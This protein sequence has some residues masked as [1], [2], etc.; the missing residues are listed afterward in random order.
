M[1]ITLRNDK[2]LNVLSI[3][4]CDDELIIMHKLEQILKKI[5]K[6]ERMPCVIEKFDSGRK[7][8]EQI[9][10]I[11]LVFLDI[12]MPELDGI[13]VGKLLKKKNPECQIIIAS[14]RG[15]RFK[16]TY[17]IDT[18]RF[19]SKPFDE[20]EIWE[21]IQAYQ[22][23]YMIGM[24]KMEVFLNR[25]AVWIRQKN[26]QYLSAYKGGVEIMVNGVLFR[27]EISLN[28]IKE[29]LNRI[30]FYQVHK[31]YVV[32]LFH[33]TG[34]TEKEVAVGKIKIPLSR[35]NRKKFESTFMEFDI[36]Y[37]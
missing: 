4:I 3:A 26:I 34:F 10:N 30:C 18:L 2:D 33:V 24:D 1:G 27:K 7:L 12:A 5:V 25:N 8:L 9:K 31:A 14:G 23:K 11:Q 22:N 37:R 17:Q 32:N 28:R 15:D 6:K 16:E 36:K 13:A 21:A 20:E 35:R 19:V 29:Q